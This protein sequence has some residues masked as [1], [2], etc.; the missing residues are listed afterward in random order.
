LTEVLT[1]AIVKEEGPLRCS[2]EVTLK[3][4]NSSHIKQLI[5]LEAESSCIKVEC[6]VS[7]VM[8]YSNYDYD[9]LILN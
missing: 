1:S 8:Q 3:I 7:R 2:V 4:S 6:N 9:K 5:I